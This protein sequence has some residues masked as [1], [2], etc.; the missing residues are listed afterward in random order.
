[1]RQARQ[2][3]L[4]VQPA[5]RVQALGF[6]QTAGVED[7]GDADVVGGQGE[8]GA[9]RFL[10]AVRQVVADLVEVLGA[11]GDALLGVQAIGY[12][13]G[14]G[15]VVG[16]HHQPAYPGLGGGVRRPQRFLVAHGGEQAPVQL[17]LLRHLAEVLLVLGQ[18]F[19]QVLGEGIG[20]D[21]A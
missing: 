9:I 11:A 12:P 14:L 17:V 8:P 1:M 13:H 2:H 19:L 3:L 7:V 21:V 20:T 6:G 5:I 4:H 15:G 18:A 10:D 16:Q